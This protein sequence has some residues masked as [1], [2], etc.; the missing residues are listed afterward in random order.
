MDAMRGEML[1]R[2]KEIESL[3]IDLRNALRNCTP[4]GILVRRLDYKT[5]KL[6]DMRAVFFNR[7]VS[8]PL[9]P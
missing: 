5:N 3:E 9:C 6:A 2:Q 8:I 7:R 1:A 4:I